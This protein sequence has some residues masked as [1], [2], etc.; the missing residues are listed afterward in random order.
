MIKRGLARKNHTLQG[1]ARLLQRI[2]LPEVGSHLRGDR[3]LRWAALELLSARRSD[4]TRR[5]PN[6]RRCSKRPGQS[7]VAATPRCITI[8]QNVVFL[9]GFS[10]RARPRTRARMAQLGLM[11]SRAPGIGLIEAQDQFGK[12]SHSTNQHFFAGLNSL[13]RNKSFSGSFVE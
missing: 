12:H 3:V 2:P 4:A 5:W 11:G 1:V 13:Q 10:I 8:G 9:R 6:A 7:L